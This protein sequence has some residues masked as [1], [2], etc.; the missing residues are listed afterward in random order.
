MSFLPQNSTLCNLNKCFENIFNSET[1]PVKRNF[2]NAVWSVLCDNIY[3]S[4]KRLF[5]RYYKN[6]SKKSKNS[7]YYLFSDTEYS[8]PEEW[9]KEILRN[10]LSIIPEKYSDNT[11]FISIDDTI[12]EKYG[13]EFEKCSDIFNHNKNSFVNGYCLLSVVITIV[14]KKII[15]DLYFQKFPSDLK[16]GFLKKS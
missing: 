7:L 4:I 8:F 1:D 16:H 14:T 9:N 6:F 11:I 13:H 15:W 12:I 5:D 3:Q 10:T 2:I